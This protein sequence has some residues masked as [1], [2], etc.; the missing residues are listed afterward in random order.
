MFPGWGRII[1]LTVASLACSQSYV[2]LKQ[3]SQE[4]PG[5]TSGAGVL[6]TVA[7]GILHATTFPRD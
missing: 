2:S 6:G 3:G 1:A 5:Q 7:I 4:S